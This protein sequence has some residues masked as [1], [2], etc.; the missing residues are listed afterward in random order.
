MGYPMT[1]AR[2]VGRN[3]LNGEGYNHTDP[4]TGVHAVGSE[5]VVRSMV[6]GDMRRLE[7]DQRDEQH[8]KLYAEHA[9]ITTEQAKLVLDLFFKEDYNGGSSFS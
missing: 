4:K 1:Y 2:L 5:E 6:R 8:L 3:G 7:H 9:G